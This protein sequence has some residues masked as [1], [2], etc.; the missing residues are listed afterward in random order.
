MIF[1]DASP[2]VALML[3]T[4]EADSCEVLLGGIESGRR[5][6]VTTPNVLEEAAFKLVFAK[7]SETLGKRNP[8]KIRDALKKDTRLRQVC[9]EVLE[10]L[11]GYIRTLERGGLTIAEVH[12]EDFHLL[13][14][15]FRETGLL[16]ADCLHLIVMDR[17]GIREIGTVDSDFRGIKQVTVTP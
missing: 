8:W 14:R 5:R 6:A 1:L 17:L 13:P 7:A 2:L 9:V 11:T 12:G 3:G 15:F 4:G 10:R 16:T